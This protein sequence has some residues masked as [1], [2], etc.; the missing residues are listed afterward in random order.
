[1]SR[2]RLPLRH[3]ALVATLGIP[4]A[5]AGAQTAAS[6]PIAS[7][8]RT[9]PVRGTVRDGGRQPI[10]GATVLLVAPNGAGVAAAT[11]AAGGF[12][13]SALGPGRHT[14]RVRALGYGPASRGVDVGDAPVLLDVDLRATATLTPVM[15]VGTA[16]GRRAD[17]HLGSADV[18]TSVSV[19]A[20]EQIARE[21]VEFNALFPLEIDRM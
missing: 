18:L 12:V 2:A 9:T 10:A 8:P 3:V 19:V 5:P 21:Q 16:A 11:D 1:M 7:V 13:V 15:V 17:P 4:L 6:P 14:L 20:G